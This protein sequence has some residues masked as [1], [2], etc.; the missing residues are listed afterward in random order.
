MWYLVPWNATK[1]L[2]KAMLDRYILDDCMVT[3]HNINN[4]SKDL[5]KGIN[6]SV[7]VPNIDIW[8]VSQGERILVY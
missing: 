6:I 2:C 5:L 8:H 7:L 1:E 4:V 3:I